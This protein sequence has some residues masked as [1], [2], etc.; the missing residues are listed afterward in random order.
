MLASLP[1][2]AGTAEILNLVVAPPLRRRGLGTLLMEEALRRMVHAGAGRVWLEVRASN[3]PA[4]ALYRRMGFRET[5]R[6]LQ[7]YQNPAEDALLLESQLS[8]C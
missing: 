1:P 4:L 5:G 3:L 2:G 6:R 7:Y 8:M